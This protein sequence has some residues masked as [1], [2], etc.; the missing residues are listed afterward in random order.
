MKATLPYVKN[1]FDR[2]NAEIFE[3]KLPQVPLA[4]SRGTR[5]LGKVEYKRVRKPFSRTVEISDIIVRISGVREFDQA[6][7]DDVIIHE[8]I[9]LYILVSGIQDTSAHGKVFRTMM[10]D[11]N[12]RFGRHITIS[13]RT[14]EEELREDQTLREHI[15]CV[16]QLPGGDLGVTV[17]SRTRVFEIMRDLPKYY[18]LEGTKWYFSICPYFN[19]FPRSNTPKIYKAVR[20]D[21][22]RALS[23]STELHYDGHSLRPER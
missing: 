17:C 5:Y 22:L 19:R 1:Q 7:L 8:M 9:H 15:V 2:Y 11:I 10:D 12:A 14:T 4:L 21:L 18:R 16:S 6:E 20:E 13:H 3:G 23:D